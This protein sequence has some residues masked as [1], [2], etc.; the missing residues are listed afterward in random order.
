MKTLVLFFLV[1]TALLS[2]CISG[3]TKAQRSIETAVTTTQEPGISDYVTGKIPE[4]KPPLVSYKTASVL[5]FAAAIIALIW[6]HGGAAICLAFGA[7]IGPTVGRLSDMLLASAVYIFFLALGL[8][9]IFA[10]YILRHRFSLPDDGSIFSK[11][12]K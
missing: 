6:K 3:K 9:L 11:S 4:G 8:G 5:M 12:P 2:G 7:I 10:W 1:F